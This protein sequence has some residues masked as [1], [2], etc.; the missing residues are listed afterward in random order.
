MVLGIPVYGLLL[1][2]LPEVAF[3]HH[4]A[5]TFLVISAFITV[6]TSVRPLADPRRLP[7]VADGVDLTPAAG[8]G[9]WAGGVIA[10]AAVLYI[11]FW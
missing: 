10:G 1:W 4:M 6:V 3:L 9:L 5:I 2:A 8:A 7:R 11:I